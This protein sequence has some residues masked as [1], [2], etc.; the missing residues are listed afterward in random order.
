MGAVLAGAGVGYAAGGKEH[1]DTY[2]GAAA[3]ATAIVGQFIGMGYTRGDEDEADDL[4]FQFYTRA[5]WDPNRFGDFF[6]HMIDK[7]YDTT[8]EMLSDHPTL[9][10]RVEKTKQRVTELPPQA[11]Q[12]RQPLVASPEKFAELQQHAVEVGKTMPTD[13][14]L[15][16]AQELLA[17]FPSCMLPK[18]QPEQKA[19]QQRILARLKKQ[20]STPAAK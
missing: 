3:G 13:Q 1:G 6:Q 20:P 7:G 12:W 10:S 11:S 17:A 14:N 16:Q 18:D 8:P 5:G 15:A 4:G 19:A 9:K 2:A